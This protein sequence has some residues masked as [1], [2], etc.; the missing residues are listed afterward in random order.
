MKDSDTKRLLKNAKTI[1]VVGCSSNPGKP[2]HDI[3]KYMKEQGYKIIPINPVSDT[4]LGE[5][6]YFS[7]KDLPA[8]TKVDIINVFRP[9]EETLNIVTSSIRLRPKLIWLQSGIEN[10]EAEQLA[11]DKNIP[12]VMDKCIMV[13]HRRLL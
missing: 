12:I 8:D 3:P 4:I 11:N 1:A 10:E 5:Q 7:L 9:S 6:C 13:K 2:S